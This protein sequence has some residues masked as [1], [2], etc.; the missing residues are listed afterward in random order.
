MCFC[1]FMCQTQLRATNRCEINSGKVVECGKGENAGTVS[2][3][4]LIL[5][6]ILSCTDLFSAFML[7]L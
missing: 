6:V 3:L 2:K 7:Y 4:E 1:V 5:P